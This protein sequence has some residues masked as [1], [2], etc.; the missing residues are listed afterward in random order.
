MFSISSDEGSAYVR[1]FKQNSRTDSE[2]ILENSHNLSNID[3]A[4][5]PLKVN[6]ISIQSDMESDVSNSNQFLEN[7][8]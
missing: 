7:F 8:K 3:N 6:E 2:K 1:L 4:A 5:E